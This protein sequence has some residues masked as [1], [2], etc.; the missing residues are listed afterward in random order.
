[1][2]ILAEQEKIVADYKLLRNTYIFL[3]DGVS[4]SPQ[5]IKDP[6]V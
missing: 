3:E 5:T 1:M 6:Q 4:T 2:P